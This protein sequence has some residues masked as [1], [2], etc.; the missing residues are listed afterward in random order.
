MFKYFKLL[1]DHQENRRVRQRFSHRPLF[2]D[3]ST[4]TDIRRVEPYELTP[5][6]GLGGFAGISFTNTFSTFSINYGLGVDV[7]ML[8]RMTALSFL[9]VSWAS[10]K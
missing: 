2:S 10:G 6:F 3:N 4:W 1:S 5:A 7:F 8:P 9:G